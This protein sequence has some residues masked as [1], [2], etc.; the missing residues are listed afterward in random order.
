MDKWATP[1]EMCHAQDSQVVGVYEQT[2]KWGQN[3]CGLWDQFWLSL[4]HKNMFYKLGV[5]LIPRQPNNTY[6]LLVHASSISE[7]T[8]YTHTITYTWLASWGAN[9]LEIVKFS[10]HEI[11]VW[12]C[13]Q[14]WFVAHE[15]LMKFT[16]GARSQPF[17]NIASLKSPHCRV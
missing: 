11:C 8:W 7:S 10:T 14:F 9:T 13:N 3:V 2:T 15:T 16:A 6:L 12:H 1:Y 4:D 17:T 5:H